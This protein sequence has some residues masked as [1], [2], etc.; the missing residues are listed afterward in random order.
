[1]RSLTFAV[2]AT[3][4]LLACGK[5]E[6]DTDTGDTDV[7]SDADTDT[8]T[9]GDTDGDTDTDTTDSDT[10]DTDADTDDTDVE[11]TDLPTGA[12]SFADVYTNVITGTCTGGAC[13][14]GGA[15]GLDMSSEAKAYANL[16]GV[17]STGKPGATRVIAGDP[18][19]SYLVLKL[20]GA[21]NI[22]GQKMPLGGNLPAADLQ[23]VKDWI[24]D[25]ANP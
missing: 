3:L 21:P 10:T 4:T 24:T 11:D 2:L 8:D 23:M 9:D 7:D 5:D 6:D 25:G 16:V 13:H 12:I 18:V 20:E 1:M 17:A 14:G 22:A 15:G 19:T